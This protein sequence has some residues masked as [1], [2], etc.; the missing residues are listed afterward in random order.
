MGV[1]GPEQQKG[2]RYQVAYHPYLAS[3]RRL[4]Y[5][6]SVECVFVLKIF[7]NLL[8]HAHMKKDTK[9]PR[10]CVLQAMKSWAEPG[11]ETILRVI[12]NGVG[13]V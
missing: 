12:H 11:N 7:P 3:R 13:W 6:P 8:C 9:F 10:F 2:P 1:E 4:S 5:T